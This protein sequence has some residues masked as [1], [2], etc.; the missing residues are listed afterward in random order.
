[1]KYISIQHI[2]V[3][4]IATF[5]FKAQCLA[6]TLEL[7]QPSGLYTEGKTVTLTIKADA[8][9]SLADLDKVMV[10]SNNRTPLDITMTQTPSEW[11]GD[12]D[13]P[14]AGWY[15]FEAH[16]KD[17]VEKE[18]PSAVGI[19]VA[20]EKIGPAKPEPT[21]FDAFW[22]QKRAEVSA[23]EF[24][25]KLTPLTAEQ[26]E[27]EYIKNAPAFEERAIRL[28]QQGMQ[29][30]NLGIDMM[31]PVRPVCGY[32]ARPTNAGIGSSPVIILLHAAGIGKSWT[33]G[34]SIRAMELAQKYNAIVLDLNAHGVM[35]GGSPEYYEKMTLQVRS[36]YQQRENW[37]ASHLAGM[38]LRLIRAV[39][40]IATLPEWD[41][42]H[43]V[44]I[45][46]SQGG[47]QALMAAG[48]D[49]RVSGVI[50]TVPAMCDYAGPLAGRSAGF[51][52]PL[53]FNTLEHSPE[54]VD[55]ILANTSYCDNIYLSKR[56]KAST[57]M[58]AGLID[59]TCP[60][61]GIAAAFNAIPTK[62]NIFYYPHKTHNKFPAEDLWI[63][64]YD[65]L[66]DD[67]LEQHFSQ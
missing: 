7:D 60:P 32:L 47:G 11:Q 3:L 61:V 34:N 29:R 56:S 22:T 15:V 49:P 35:N 26:K 2:A 48:L 65:E 41:G 18:K 24:E 44:C 14:T 19:L 23:V 46:D 9:N 37:D 63:G 51:P 5:A 33:I 64:K 66:R 20:P 38:A 45:G 27:Q 1:M 55:S 62:K 54:T 53:T 8:D 57:L 13:P 21:D 50:A 31:T 58:F 10:L 16:H 40:F 52:Y 25:P 17:P 42:K 28:E 6:F 43:I 12:F 39:D 4:V 59:P 36:L 30:W 67:F